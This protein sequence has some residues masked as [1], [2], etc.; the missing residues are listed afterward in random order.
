M[1]WQLSQY[2]LQRVTRFGW[3]SAAPLSHLSSKLM[4]QVRVT[5]RKRV[6]FTPILCIAVK[7]G[8]S[9]QWEV[10]TWGWPRWLSKWWP[11]SFSW[12]LAY[13]W[14]L[15]LPAHLSKAS[16]PLYIASAGRMRHSRALVA[17]AFLSR[18]WLARKKRTSGFLQWVRPVIP[19]AECP[20][21]S[22]IWKCLVEKHNCRLLLCC[23]QKSRPHHKL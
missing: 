1:F 7:S 21:S 3:R 18:W 13:R 22:D 16:E 23:L 19:L 14:Q 5:V 4:G 6:N 20:S 12:C 10:G 17:I 2:H 9:D 8:W 15:S 11:A